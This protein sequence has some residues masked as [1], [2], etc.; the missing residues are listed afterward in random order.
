M[1]DKKVKVTLVKSA[2][3]RKPEHR[4]TLRALG[5]RKTNA[6]RIHTLNPAVKGMIQQV[7]YMLKVEDYNG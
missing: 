2:I 6:V 5:L 3:G 7:G 1:S 4:A